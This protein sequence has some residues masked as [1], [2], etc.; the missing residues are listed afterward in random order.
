VLKR[1]GNNPSQI[2]IQALNMINQN[3][4]SEIRAWAH[5]YHNATIHQFCY[6]NLGNGWVSNP[7]Y[8]YGKLV[9]LVLYKRFDEDPSYFVDAAKEF[10]KAN[11]WLI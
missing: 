10:M 2:L 8:E 3:D 11:H 6:R 4:K 5:D 7:T 1:V 9:Y